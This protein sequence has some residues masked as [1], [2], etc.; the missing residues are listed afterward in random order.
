MNPTIMPLK[1]AE[2]WQLEKVKDTSKETAGLG[3]CRV[4]SSRSEIDF[5]E[6]LYFLKCLGNEISSNKRNWFRDFLHTPP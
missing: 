1:M 5:W 2:L 3:A 4:I 6:G